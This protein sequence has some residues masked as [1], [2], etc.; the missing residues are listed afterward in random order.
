MSL[1]AVRTSLAGPPRAPSMPAVINA[2]AM[3]HGCQTC[4]MNQRARKAI[5]WCIAYEVSMARSRPMVQGHLDIG[6]R[7]T[8][9]YLAEPSANGASYRG[10]A[11]VAAAQL[12][13]CSAGRRDTTALLYP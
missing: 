3:I 2:N 12:G 1:W 13:Q 4:F 7:A 6:V 5:A 9:D 8:R 10:L 11:G